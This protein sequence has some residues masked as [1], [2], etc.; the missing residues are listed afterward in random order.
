M[1]TTI[2]IAT[3]TGFYV[4]EVCGVWLAGFV[5]FRFGVFQYI[6]TNTGD[7]YYVPMS[8]HFHNDVSFLVLNQHHLQ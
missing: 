4:L 7:Q 1:I 6:N 5:L 8:A 2:S 3:S